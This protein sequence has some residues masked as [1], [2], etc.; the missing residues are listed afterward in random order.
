MQRNQA[1]SLKGWQRVCRHD[2]EALV[3]SSLTP[4]S[5][6]EP[7][8]PLQRIYRRLTCYEQ[9]LPPPGLCRSDDSILGHVPKE[10]LYDPDSMVY[11]LKSHLKMI[12]EFAQ[13]FNLVV[14]EH[15]AIDCSFLELV[16]TLYKEVANF[17]N[18]HALCDPSTS[19][20]RR[21]RPGTPPVVHCAGAA[22]IRI[23]VRFL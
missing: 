3:K 7:C 19:G 21:S 14:S 11:L 17:V 20:S 8:D 23:S 15:V 1:E 4:T 10:N 2:F 12:E 6:I 5:P 13:N 22:I 18:L 16:P 9:P